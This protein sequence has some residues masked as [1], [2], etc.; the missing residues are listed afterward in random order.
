MKERLL[1]VTAHFPGHTRKRRHA[2][3]VLANFNDPG[4][5]KLPKAGLQLGGEFH[6]Q[7]INEIR[8]CSTIFCGYYYRISTSW[9]SSGPQRA[10]GPEAP[11]GGR[12]AC[13]AGRRKYRRARA[14]TRRPGAPGRRWQKR[15]ADRRHAVVR[16]NR[17]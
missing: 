4:R 2:A 7:I 9:D 12:H 10:A 16:S 8:K 14:K 17:D 3:A 1:A 5:G 15:R 13:A 11:E 6:D